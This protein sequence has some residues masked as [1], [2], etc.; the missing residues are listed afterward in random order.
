M[1]ESSINRVSG[2]QFLLVKELLSR[3]DE[4]L[5]QLDAL[6]V[7]VEAAIKQFVGKTEEAGPDTSQ[8]ETDTSP[9]LPAGSVEPSFIGPSKAA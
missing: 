9:E 5:E 6:D 3:Q 1:S 8:N 7:Q 2:D 4:V